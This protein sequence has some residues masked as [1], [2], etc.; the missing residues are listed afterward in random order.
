MSQNKKIM[1]NIKIF[2][3][4]VEKSGIFSEGDTPLQFLAPNGLKINF[5]HW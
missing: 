5:G 2:Q 4:R 1:V 3:R